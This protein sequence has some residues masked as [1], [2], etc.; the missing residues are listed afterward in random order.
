MAGSCADGASVA[1]GFAVVV[2]TGGGASAG[3]VV[4][5]TVV[6]VEVV[7]GAAV[8]V[9]VWAPLADP[10]AQEPVTM[11]ARSRTESRRTP[12]R[13]GRQSPF[14]MSAMRSPASV[15]FWATLTPAA[16][17]ASILAWAVP[18]EPEMMAPAWPIFF[19]GGAVTPAT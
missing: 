8:V 10:P 9:V 19:P 5:T 4:G 17:S 12:P 6:E 13:L 16:A 14:T 7:V 11:S 1:T 3:A 18:L 2:V 15:G